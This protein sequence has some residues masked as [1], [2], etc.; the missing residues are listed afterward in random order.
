MRRRC[1]RRN[2][3]GVASGGAQW[4]QRMLK[5]RDEEIFRLV[6]QWTKSLQQEV[7]ERKQAQ[8]ALQESQELIMRQERLA[9][10]GQLAAGLAHEFN[11]ILTVVQGH[12]LPAVEQS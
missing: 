9:A 10:A 3:G 7:A 11:N 2:R 1:D 12:A 5:Q 4:R 6:D 8:R